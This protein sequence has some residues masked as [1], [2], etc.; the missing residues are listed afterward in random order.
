MM[1]IVLM[2]RLDF[3]AGDP[4]Y[5]LY[6]IREDDLERAR[7]AVLAAKKAWDIYLAEQ[8]LEDL[9]Q[10]QFKN[11]GIMYESLNNDVLSLYVF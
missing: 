5:I 4:E 10:K 6:K 8:S 11:N 7:S 2:I 3:Q 9:I 1:D